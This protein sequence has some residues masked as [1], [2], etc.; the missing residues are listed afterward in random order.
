MLLTACLLLVVAISPL[1]IAFP[2]TGFALTRLGA[3]LLPALLFLR[4]GS[5][6][7]A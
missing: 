1:Q 7:A 5:A 6:R 2:R 4:V 3:I